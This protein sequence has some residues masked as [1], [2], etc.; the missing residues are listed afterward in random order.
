MNHHAR[1]PDRHHRRRHRYVE[2]TLAPDPEAAPYTV[3]SACLTCGE[4]SPL[5]ESTETISGQ[6]HQ[7]QRWCTSHAAADH[8]DGR[9][10]RYTATVTLRW[11]V[12]PAE[13]IGPTAP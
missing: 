12:T 8:P 4:R 1:R 11:H 2:M 10:L 7:A 6:H 3:R 5:P 9:H 13:D